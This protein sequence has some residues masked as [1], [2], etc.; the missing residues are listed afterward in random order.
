MGKSLNMKKI[1]CLT[2]LFLLSCGG[3]LASPA[4]EVKAYRVDTLRLRIEYRAGGTD[5]DLDYD[6]N[7]ASWEAFEK[8][9]R[10][11]Q[12]D[13]NA[14]LMGFRV[15]TGTSFDGSTA[16]NSSVSNLR[17]EGI[18]IFLN[19]RLG[20]GAS[21]MHVNRE[22]ENWKELE[23]AVVILSA[24]EFPWREDVLRIIRDGAME[25]DISSM[26]EDPRKAR[27]RAYSNGE[28]WRWLLRNVYPSLRCSEV[29]AFFMVT[30]PVVEVVETE[31]QAGERIVIR[32]TVVKTRIVRDTVLLSDKTHDYKFEQRVKGKKFVVALRTNCLAVPFANVGAEFPI[33]KHFS[34][35]VDYYYPW[36]WR[37]AYHKE[38]NELLAYGLDF[39]WWPGRN[40]V[41]K[42]SRLLGHS[43]GVY[44][45]GG[46]YDFEREW[47]GYQGTFWNVGF[48][49]MYAVP[50]FHGRIHLEFEIGLGMI[51]SMAKPYNVFFEYGDCIREPGVTKV[52]R[53]YG[54]TRAQVSVVVPLYINAGR[55][56]AR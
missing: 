10:Q 23:D 15:R 22:K 30:R 42:E 26:H 27:L 21:F 2:F 20:A 33:G 48:D 5:V 56:T 29:Y 35:G 24:D 8:E 1:V 43:F 50:V 14:V 7:A 52:V 54:P 55:R 37:N 11:E 28:A 25:T 12:A 16:L 38:C 36:I 34:V 31:P 3:L 4:G 44:G 17:A 41:P 40:G 53:W 47:K 49:W 46:H 19:E 13:P 39:R 45:A 6:G 32:D 9:F 51:F 18:R